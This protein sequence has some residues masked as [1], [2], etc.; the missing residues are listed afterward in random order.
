[1]PFHRIIRARFTCLGIEAAEDLVRIPHDHLVER[2]AHLV[3][4]VAPEMLIGEK[5]DLL[6]ALERPL[7]RRGRV[8][9]RAHDAA[10]LAAER[11]DRRR[12]VDVGHRDHAADAH[13][14]ELFP[15][16]RSCSGSAMSAIEQPAARSGRMTC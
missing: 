15:A 13:L 3:G 7:Q 12:G 6:A 5:E 9:R 2:D 11:F 16:G 10:V 1:M 4:G 8:R 14:R